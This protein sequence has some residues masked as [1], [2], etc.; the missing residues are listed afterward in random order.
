MK[1]EFGQYVRHGKYGCGTIVEVDGS[2]TM[3]YFRNVGIKKFDTYTTAFDL[4]GGTTQKEKP[5]A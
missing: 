3:V 1:L 4:I 2:R 5:T